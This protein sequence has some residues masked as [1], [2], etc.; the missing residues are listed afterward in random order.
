MAPATAL[1]TLA[2]LVSSLLFFSCAGAPKKV[3]AENDVVYPYTGDMIW[4]QLRAE[5]QRR[6]RIASEDRETMTIVTEWDV[7]L[8]PMNTFGRRNRLEIVCTG[9][10]EDGYKIKVTQESERNTNQE[11]PLHESE[12]DWESAE[13]DGALAHRLLYSF[14][15]RMNPK[16]PWAEEEDR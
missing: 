2:L 5:V 13:T 16:V 11:N 3:D 8:Q 15:R 4:D 9:S 6:V 14:N 1:R 7:A 10:D 12:A